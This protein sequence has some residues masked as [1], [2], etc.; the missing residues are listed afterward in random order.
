MD[1]SSVA[2]LYEELD[3]G[4]HEWNGHGNVHSVREDKVGVLSELLDDAEDVI[5]PATVQS[6][7]VVPEFEDNLIHLKYC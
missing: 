4:L 3:V 5:P 7:A 6:R 1:T 2:G